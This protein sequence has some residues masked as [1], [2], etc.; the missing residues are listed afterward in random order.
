[1]NPPTSLGYRTDLML[2]TLQGSLV[3]QRDGY[4]VVRT[5]SNPTFYW[6]NFLLLAARPA[7]GTAAEWVR[8]FRREFPDAE[9]VALG[10]DSVDGDAGETADLAAAHLTVARNTVLTTTAVQPPPRPNTQATYRALSGDDDWAQ[11]LTISEPGTE[12]SEFARARMAGLRTLQD[13]GHGAWFGAFKADQMVAGLGLF[14]DDN[15]VARYQ[16]VDTHPSHRNQGL[17]STL[18]HHAAHHIQTHHNA[19]HLAIVADPTYTAI[20]IYKTLGF[21]DKETQLQLQLE[22]T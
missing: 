8:T 20:N 12:I 21:T 22:P 9:H 10:I 11:A 19:N 13:H 7:P 18:L 6:G 15:G 17:A 3:E 2:L 5:P 4:L 16:N 14:T 1:M